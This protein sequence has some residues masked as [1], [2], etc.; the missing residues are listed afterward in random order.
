MKNN[1]NIQVMFY[2]FQIITTKLLFLGKQFE[3]YD[4]IDKILKVLILYRY[5]K[6]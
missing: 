2:K 3:N 6:K 1:E 5:P 4:L